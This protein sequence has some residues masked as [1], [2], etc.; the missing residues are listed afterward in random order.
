MHFLGF[1]SLSFTQKKAVSPILLLWPHLVL[2]VV[3]AQAWGCQAKT[4]HTKGQLHVN[5]FLFH[6][7]SLL[8][9]MLD[10][11]GYFLSQPGSCRT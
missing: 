1:I 11:I 9:F 4:W 5:Q 3:L 10:P 6:C 2:F 8:I 7:K